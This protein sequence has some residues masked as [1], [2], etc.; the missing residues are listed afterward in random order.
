MSN[1]AALDLMQAYDL[2][3][4][5]DLAYKV[6]TKEFEA[7]DANKIIGRAGLLPQLSANFYQA[8]N[9]TRI[10]QAGYNTTNSTYAST[11]GGV[12]LTQALIN[13]NAWASSKQGYAQ[14][15]MAKHNKEKHTK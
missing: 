11:N 10:S 15:D 7:G 1:A 14:A 3:L 8:S 9:N 2:A 12:Q 5:N 6:A 4:V 13:L